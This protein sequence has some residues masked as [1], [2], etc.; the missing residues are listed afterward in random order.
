MSSPSFLS[1][2]PMCFPL[3]RKQ[4][5]KKMLSN[6]EHLSPIHGSLPDG[7]IFIADSLFG[8]RY[9]PVSSSFCLRQESIFR[10]MPRWFSIRSRSACASFLKIAS[11]IS[12]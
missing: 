6:R 2:L 8:R 9:D 5:E 11:R 10:E 3:L 4:A 7:A 1:L 12:L